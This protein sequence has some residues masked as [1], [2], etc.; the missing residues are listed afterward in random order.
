MSSTKAVC[1][2]PA[3]A[4]SPIALS[5]PVK[6]ADD[7]DHGL[8]L[9]LKG[10]ILTVQT[11]LPLMTD[12]AAIIINTSLSQDLGL[13]TFGVY[14]AVKAG[15]RSVVRTLINE[16]RDRKIRVNA[17]SPGV[18]FTEV[19]EKDMGKE[20]TAAYVERVVEKI[21]AGRIGLLQHAR[22][23]LS[24]DSTPCKSSSVDVWARDQK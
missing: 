18:I 7:I 6:A 9:D 23:Q 22:W 16:L 21:P 3:A 15:L 17:V 12:G 1:G 8:E 13:P 24:P 5:S 4:F 2:R 10:T 14:A 19:L 20:A 11:A